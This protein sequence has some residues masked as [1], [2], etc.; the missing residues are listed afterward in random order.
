MRDAGLANAAL[1]AGKVIIIDK[2]AVIA[3]AR[4][5]NIALQGFE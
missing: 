5:W 1:E 4:A 3:Q 2:P